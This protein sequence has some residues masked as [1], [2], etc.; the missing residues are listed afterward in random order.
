MKYDS[1]FLSLTQNHLTVPSPKGNAKLIGRLRPRRRSSRLSS[2]TTAAY[3]DSHSA[4]S[5]CAA[6]N[7]YESEISS[8]NIKIS[9]W[10]NKTVD[11]TQRSGSKI[12]RD[13][14]GNLRP[15]PEHRLHRNLHRRVNT[16]K[17]LTHQTDNFT[18]I[19]PE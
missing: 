3:S 2:A 16:N 5:T 6:D 15:V 11:F 4:H 18:S 14:F 10:L 12:R 9:D 17:T 1:E 8:T 7:C 13:M 19:R